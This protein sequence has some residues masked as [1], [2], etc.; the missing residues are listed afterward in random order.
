MW[1][2][3]LVDLLRAEMM[4]TVIKRLESNLKI[5]N[6]L[7]LINTRMS[8]NCDLQYF[9]ND[10]LHYFLLTVEIKNSTKSRNN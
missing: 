7:T 10:Y 2:R 1:R 3:N 4:K 9:F 6:K 8:Q 5:Y